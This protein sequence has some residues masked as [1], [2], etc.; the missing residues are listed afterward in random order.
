MKIAVAGGTGVVGTHVVREAEYAGHEVLSL[1]RSTGV[2]LTS[3]TGLAE[4]LRGVDAVIDCLSVETVKRKVAVDFFT[5]TTRTL[6]DAE[7]AAGVPHHLVLSIV[8]VDRVRYGHYDGKVAQE[9]AVRDSGRPFTILRATQFHEFAEQMSRRGRLGP[10]IAMPRIAAAPVAAR[11]VAQALLDLAGLPPAGRTYELGGPERRD[12][13]DMARALARRTGRRTPVVPLVV[14]GAAS[15]AM[16]SGALVPHD[17][18]RTG[19]ET[20][21]AWLASRTA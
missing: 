15:K 7:Q 16:R 21:D 20:Y 1:S 18:W 10:I 2:D 12:L 9:H 11:E 6:L 17:P 8:G 5:T 3:G 13:V 4:H 19:V 14:P